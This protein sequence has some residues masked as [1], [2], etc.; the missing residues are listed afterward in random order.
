LSEAEQPGHWLPLTSKD[1]F[2]LV[3]YAT[4]NIRADLLSMVCSFAPE[5]LGHN[6][7]CFR[8]WTS[9]EKLENS[10]MLGC[11]L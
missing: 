11:P 6:D 4:F 7:L 3:L 5:I 8:A 1:A 9:K 2:V 10:P